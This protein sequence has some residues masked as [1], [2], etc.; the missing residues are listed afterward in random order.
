VLWN[1]AVQATSAL[2]VSLAAILMNLI[3]LGAGDPPGH[4]SLRNCIGAL[5]G[6][7]LIGALSILSFARLPAD[8]GATVSRQA[9][10]RPLK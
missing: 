4:V 10:L 9:G 7:A 3:A 5:L 8:A 2:G 1:L 6:M